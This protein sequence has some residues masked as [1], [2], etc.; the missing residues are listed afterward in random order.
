MAEKT[1][2]KRVTF[3]LQNA[4]ARKVLVAG[5]FNGWDTSHVH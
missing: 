1:T 4:E 5:S 3:R 2:K